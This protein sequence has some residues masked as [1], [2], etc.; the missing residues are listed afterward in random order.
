MLAIKKAESLRKGTAMEDPVIKHL[1]DRY[2]ETRD[3]TLLQQMADLLT[4]TTQK[5]QIPMV[6]SQILN[7]NPREERALQEI[8]TRL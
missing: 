3:L 4:V 2:R 1:A 7:L 5:S 8:L 6:I